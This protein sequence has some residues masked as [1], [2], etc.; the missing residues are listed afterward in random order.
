MNIN[1]KSIVKILSQSIEFDWKSPFN[2]SINKDSI[3]TGFFIDKNYIIT[4]SHVVENTI[5]IYI[6]IPSL[7]KEK[8]E[9]ELISCCP[10]IDIALLK[11]INYDSS[12][13][14]ELDD[15][16]KVKATNKVYAVGYPL[17]LDNAKY[18]SGIVSGVQDYFFQTDAPIN[19]GNSGGPLI[20][21]NNKVIAINSAKIPKSEG[22][23]FSIPINFF[24]NMKELMMTHKIIRK[25]TLLLEFNNIEKNLWNYCTEN[26]IDNKYNTGYYIKKCYEDS[27]LY[28]NY[29]INSGDILLELN[30]YKLDNYGEMIVPWSDEKI[31]LDNLLRRYNLNQTINIKIWS[32]RDKKIKDINYKLD[33]LY[34]INISF[35]I[36]EKIDYFIFGGLVIMNFC[37]NH[38]YEFD[39]Y[40]KDIFEFNSMEFRKKPKV[41]ISQILSGSTIKKDNIMVDGDLLLSIN[42]EKV[43]SLN[44]ILK[45]VDKTFDK[46]K[47]YLI[48]K[49]H[50]DDTICLNIKL[51]LFETYNLSKIYGYKWQNDLVTLLVHKLSD[52]LKK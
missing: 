7:G 52:E 31:N 8:Y 46:Y 43:E 14:M 26:K 16:D 49:N 1:L 10:Y 42:D 41:I 5:K 34:P 36:I 20:N 25:C 30:G 23:G 35:P 44:D 47:G 40:Y 48:I 22:M 11:T 19:E 38:L 33:Y 18:S 24:K 28:I 27:S 2:K 3:G 39:G 13:F 4:C 21:E 45:V 9:A 17:G 6:T 12:D 32:S 51:G 37:L 15:S 50:K 29:G